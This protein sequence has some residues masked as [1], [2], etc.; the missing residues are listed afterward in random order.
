MGVGSWFS[1]G[2]G[3]Q[4]LKGNGVVDTKGGGI[5]EVNCEYQCGEF[6]VVTGNIL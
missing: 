6:G 4:V 2:T 5:E 1:K 3:W